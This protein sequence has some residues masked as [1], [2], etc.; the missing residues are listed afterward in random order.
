MKK[1]SAKIKLGFDFLG[2]ALY[3]FAGLGI[4][5]I[6]VY[7]IEPMIYGGPMEEW[8]VS[9]SI[10]HWI[11]T[12]IT[13]G[14]VALLLAKISKKKYSFDLFVKN[15]SEIK[16]WQWLCTL[17]CVILILFIMYRDWNGF[18]PYIEYQRLGLPKFIFQ[19]IYYAFET[20]LFMLILIFGQK[21]CEAWFQKENI[22]YGGIIVVVTWGLVHILTKGSLMVGILSATVGFSYGVVY[23]LLNRDIKKTYIVLFIMFAI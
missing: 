5:G 9:Q 16:V 14:V 2:L 21:A 13:W 15:N 1:L 19:Y 20:I 17:L 3:A 7:L 8:T 23:L 22:P 10:L 12:C 4:E 11:I 18:K 6:Y